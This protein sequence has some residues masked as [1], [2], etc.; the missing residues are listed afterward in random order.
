MK[1]FWA[2]ITAFFMAIIAFFTGLFA[3]GNNPD[4]QPEPEPTSEVTV[5]PTEPAT[6]PT[7][8]TEPATEPAVETVGQYGLPA[9]PD[10]G[11]PGVFQS[12]GSTEIVRYE[13]RTAADFDAYR[14]TLCS[15]GYTVYDTHEIEQ[16][17]FATLLS[18]SLTVSL[19]WF[20][21]TKVLRVIAEERGAL[22]PLTDSA[23]GE[24]DTLLTGMKGETVVADEGMGFI[25]RLKDGSFCIID[26][27]M[28]DPDSVD[29]DK[30]MDI[31][32]A[33]KPA[34]AEKPVI[35]AW[36]FTHLHGD[37]VGVFNCFSLDHHDDVVL[38]RLLFNFPKEEEIAVS[39][40]LY[41]LDDSIYRW[42]Q[43]KQNL[44]DFYA[45]VPV[46]KLHSGN[47]F[48]VRNAQFEVL[49]ALDDLYPQSILTEG[50]NG[51]NESSL[52]FKMTVDG[53]TTLWTGDFGFLAADLVLQEYTAETLK[54]DILQMAHHGWNGTVPLYSAVD[55]TYALLPISFSASLEDMLSI[56]PNAWLRDSENVRQIIVTNCGTWTMKLPYAPAEGTFDRIPADD[57]V[58]PSY[59]D[60]LGG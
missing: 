6:E 5:M 56:A 39:D 23:E 1:A 54:S 27:G 49:F 20:A 30:L 36:I 26:G 16:N 22:C 57:A 42:N 4:P 14:Q 13:N 8:P 18:D 59:P 31:L 29:S 48:T 50:G 60:L 37:H 7:A 51:L 53:Q 41:M 28:G 10:A 11:E 17:R 33:Q 2:K 3:G 43:F 38:E 58:Y 12:A 40:S 25:I 47:R 55:P 44:A 35:A 46:V 19:S 45:D 32:N 52:L 21:G 9:V 34:D 24:Y 15:M